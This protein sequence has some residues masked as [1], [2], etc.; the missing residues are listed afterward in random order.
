VVVVDMSPFPAAR[1][2]Q[3]GCGPVAVRTVRVYATQPVLGRVVEGLSKP[4]PLTRCQPVPPL[5]TR[6]VLVE[7]PRER[8]SEH[9]T[10]NRD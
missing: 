3:V 5:R 1:F 2:V 9:S 10:K 7:M 8:S 4:L 6:D